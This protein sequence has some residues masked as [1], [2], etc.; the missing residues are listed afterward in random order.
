MVGFIFGF[1]I[2]LSMLLEGGLRPSNFDTISLIDPFRTCPG[3]GCGV[4]RLSVVLMGEVEF[5]CGEAEGYPYIVCGLCFLGDLSPDRNVDGIS[6]LGGK[7][8]E[9]S[10]S[11]LYSFVRGDFESLRGLYSFDV[12]SCG[13]G[14]ADSGPSSSSLESG[15]WRVGVRPPSL[16]GWG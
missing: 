2:G 14:V 4:G 9:R 3:R 6:S 13:A 16:G 11:G 1:D 12:D 8:A 5:F 10:S 7:V 15:S